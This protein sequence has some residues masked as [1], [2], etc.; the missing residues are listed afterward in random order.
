MNN[1]TPESIFFLN[2]SIP[3][4]HFLNGSIQPENR[5][6]RDNKPSPRE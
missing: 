5:G 6:F 2:G 1:P 4:T 3:R